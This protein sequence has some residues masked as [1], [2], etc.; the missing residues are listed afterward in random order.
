MEETSQRIKDQNNSIDKDTK[1]LSEKIIELKKILENNKITST[2][3]EKL[4][5]ELYKKNTE[6]N[7]KYKD[8]MKEYNSQKDNNKIL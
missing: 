5:K 7:I 6:I 2:Y 8:I 1:N 4:R 3:E